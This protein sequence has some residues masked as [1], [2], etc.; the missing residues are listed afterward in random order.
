M[1]MQESIFCFKRNKLDSTIC[2]FFRNKELFLLAIR[3]FNS[4]KDITYLILALS[5]VASISVLLY[6][7]N[8]HQ[9][10]LINGPEL[11]DFTMSKKSSYTNY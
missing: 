4:I 5:A 11:P 2:K 7:K 3:M 6:I 9:A 10:Q 1:V 8:V